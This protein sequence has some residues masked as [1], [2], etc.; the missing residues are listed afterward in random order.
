[1]SDPDG[2]RRR[3]TVYKGELAQVQI[4]TA[5]GRVTAMTGTMS[6]VV[7]G[8]RREIPIGLS[9]SALTVVGHM[10]RPGLVAFYGEVDETGFRVIGPDLR[11]KTLEE[12]ERLARR[13]RR[14]EGPSPADAARGGRI[15]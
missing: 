13:R 1:M 6:R 8:V 12:A 5:G 9:G 3:R 7:Q 15:P 14:R 2:V 11:R 10:F 4:V